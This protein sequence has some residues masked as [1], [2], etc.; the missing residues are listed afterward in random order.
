M[1]NPESRLS[2]FPIPGHALGA[3]VGHWFAGLLLLYCLFLIQTLLSPY[4]PDLVLLVL[5]TIAMRESRF[6]A[7][8][9][10]FLAGLCLD[11]ASPH[12]AGANIVVYAGFAYVVALVRGFLNPSPWHTLI[13]ISLGLLLRYAV[14]SI[15]RALPPGSF[16]SSPLTSVTVAAGL[17]LLLA[18]PAE[19]V[20]SRT[21]YRRWKSS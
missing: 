18:L 11:L 13:F 15:V 4:G 9:L 14:L 12:S 3:R 1:G 7:A 2:R 21:L 16:G 10:G 5:L 19:A 8:L 17:T 20:I 6:A